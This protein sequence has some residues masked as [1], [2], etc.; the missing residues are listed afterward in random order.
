M[1]SISASSGGAA[2]SAAAC[3]EQVGGPAPDRPATPTPRRRASARLAAV[4]RGEFGAAGGGGRHAV[5]AAGAGPVRN[6][7]EAVGDAV[8]G[9]DAGFAEV[10]R[11][12]VGRG[13]RQRGGHGAVDASRARVRRG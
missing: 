10:P 12:Q 9:A 5:R 2:A 1:S 6:G 7:D 11:P 3:L 4:L 13:I 8:V